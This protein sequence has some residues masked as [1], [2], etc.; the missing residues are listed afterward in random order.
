MGDPLQTH[1]L[2]IDGKPRH[3]KWSMQAL[4]ILQKTY[5]GKKVLDVLRNMDADVVCEFAAAGM[6][7]AGDRKASAERVGIWIDKD[8]SMFGPLSRL[9]QAG[10]L[11]AYKRFLPEED[12]QEL[13]E[14][15]AVVEKAAAKEA[16]EESTSASLP[17][18]TSTSQ[19][20]T[21]GRSSAS[22]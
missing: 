4:R 10:V 18:T 12:Q 5:D 8:P 13:G 16:E 7:G 19:S 20:P 11:A 3:F 22:S 2:H 6:V 17:S 1:T 21:D 15:L 14:A 9:C